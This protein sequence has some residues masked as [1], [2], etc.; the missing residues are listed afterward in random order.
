MLMYVL[1]RLDGKELDLF[2]AL[3]LLTTF[4][5]GIVISH[6]YRYLILWRNWLRLRIIQ[7][8]P[9]V[10]GASLIC[11]LLYFFSHSFISELIHRTYDFKLEWLEILQTTLNL[12][13]IFMVWSL[14]YFLF[15]FIQNYRKEEIKNLKWQAAKNEMEL[16]KLK[17]Q[18][19]PHFIFNS[20]NS[21]RALIDEDPQKSKQ[22]VTRLA[23]ILR[24]SLLM[25]KKK[26]I[27]F[28]EELQLVK[29]YLNLEKTRFEERLQC[30]FQI[31][32]SAKDHQIPPMLLQTLVENGIKHGISKLTDGG[33]I[34]VKAWKE[35]GVLNLVIFNS[36]NYDENEKGESGFG[37]A[38]TRQRL[39]LLYGK[40]AHFHIKNVEDGVI[41]ELVIPDTVREFKY[42]KDESINS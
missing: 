29:D 23:N 15:H 10:L 22:S 4:S 24:S 26:V 35:N 8:I 25:G 30:H 16:N 7:L 12:A 42:E 6:A 21:I 11:G 1:N 37:L 38:N 20:M 34:E 32:D 19:N 17:S 2:F 36:G 13:V 28:S 40:N 41:A 18:L 39:K 27:T 33:R 31:D 3:N 9:R 14:L 5:L